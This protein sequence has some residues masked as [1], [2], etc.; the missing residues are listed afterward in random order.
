MVPERINTIGA[1][2]DLD[3][4]TVVRSTQI[5]DGAFKGALVV[6][7]PVLWERTSRRSGFHAW[8]RPVAHGARKTI[9]AILNSLMILME[10]AEPDSDLP[11]TV[12]VLD[13]GLEAG[14]VGRCKDGDDIELQAESDHTTEGVTK[15]TCPAKDRVVVELDIV[16][17]TVLPPMINERFCGEVR[18]PRRSYPSA[19]QSSVQADPRQNVHGRT[20]AK[21]KVFDEIETVEFALLCSNAGQVPAFWRRRTT[22]PPRRST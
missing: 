3:M 16:W 5:D 7:L 13:E 2:L 6:R 4:P 18:G 9:G 14:L 11:A 22:T 8:C 10:K 15:L 1:S 12:E 19:T 21:T 20:T 17:E